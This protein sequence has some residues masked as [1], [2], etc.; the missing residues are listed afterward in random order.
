MNKKK[1]ALGTALVAGA[2][3]LAGIL[4]AP[5]SG[6]ETRKDIA[7][8]AVKAK[9]ETEKKLKQAHSEIRDLITDAEEKLKNRLNRIN[10]F[11]IICSSSMSSN[12]SQGHNKYPFQLCQSQID[13]A[14]V[15]S[16]F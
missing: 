9:I 16:D 12:Q 7:N 6:K 10:T 2:G 1:V 3:Y 4:T 15:Y 8:T 13:Q 5:K 14:Y 11:R